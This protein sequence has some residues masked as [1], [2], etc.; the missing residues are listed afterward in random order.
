MSKYSFVIFFIITFFSFSPV[1]AQSF[2]GK[3]TDREN[4]QPLENVHVLNKRNG[5]GATTDSLGMFTLQ[6]NYKNSDTIIFSHVGYRRRSLSIGQ[7]KSNGFKIA[8][9]KETDILSNVDLKQ[10]KISGNIHYIK[11]ANLPK[12]LY[13]FSANL[14]HDKIFVIAGNETMETKQALKLMEQYADQTF[15]SYIRALLTRPNMDWFNFNSEIYTYNFDKDEWTTSKKPVKARAYHNS[16]VVADHIYIYGG[17]TL[18]RNRLKEYLP[19]EVEVFDI[20]N[21]TIVV[22]ETNPHMAI[23]FASFSKDSLIFLMGGSVKRYSTTDKKVYSN[24]VH[25]F[26]TRTGFWTE[27]GPMP[28][29][30]E[31]SGVLIG[32][33]FYMIGGFKRKKLNT[34]ETYDLRTGKWKRIGT[35]FEA[36][37]RPALAHKDETIYIY[38]NDRIITFNTTTL[39]LKE[40]KI[41]IDLHHSKMI[42]YANELYILGGYRTSQFELRPSNEFYKIP[43]ENFETTRVIREK[44]L[45][46]L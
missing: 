38:E 45:D 8:L 11:L 32:D 46:S 22:D 44:T 43:L 30:K 34:I 35:L 1:S 41:S 36:M 2:E 31:T 5:Y 39:T 13:M 15:E 9:Q 28:E 3:V 14:F 6:N 20:A 18:S 37:E 29:G 40:Y 26:N 4:E 23:N 17:K 10:R 7:F 33:I 25:V 42:Q 12:P 21:D 24:K 16:E 19:N 27:L